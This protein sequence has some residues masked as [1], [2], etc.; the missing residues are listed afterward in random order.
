MQY[1][2]AGRESEIDCISAVAEQR[3][4]HC[5]RSYHSV[6]EKARASATD[7]TERVACLHD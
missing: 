6:G 3:G 4:P 2:H 5:R 7:A 1:Q